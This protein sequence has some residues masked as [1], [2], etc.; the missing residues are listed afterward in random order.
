VV[1]RE[2]EREREREK[3]NRRGTKGDK[4]KKKERQ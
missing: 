2:R 4:G 3:Q 1:R